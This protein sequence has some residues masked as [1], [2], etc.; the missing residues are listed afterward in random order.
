MAWIC[1]SLSTVNVAEAVPKCT[2]DAPVNPEP[3]M[4]T[5]V[6]AVP[7]VGVRLVITGR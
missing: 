7:E 4:I 6:P 1:P 3:L 2:D 5:E